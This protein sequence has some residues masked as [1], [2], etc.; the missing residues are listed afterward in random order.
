MTS[1]CRRCGGVGFLL[2]VRT[3]GAAPRASAPGRGDRAP[4]SPAPTSGPG[5][6]RACRAKVIRYGHNPIMRARRSTSPSS[7]G[8]FLL[9][10]AGIDVGADRDDQRR[11]IDRPPPPPRQR[12]FINGVAS[13]GRFNGAA[14]EVGSRAIAA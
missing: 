7:G 8:L 4:A 13:P 14:R 6:R 10:R 2:D 1:V 12:E 3:G 11:V 9:R 5:S